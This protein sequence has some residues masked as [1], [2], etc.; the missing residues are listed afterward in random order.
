MNAALRP[1][2]FAFP[3]CVLAQD[4]T[5]STDVKVVTLLASVRNPD[6]N[7][8]KDLTKDDFELREDGR[9]QTIP[10]FSRAEP[11][12]AGT[13]ESA[14]GR[15]GGRGGGSGFGIDSTGTAGGWC[16]KRAMTNR[17]VLTGRAFRAPG[18]FFNSRRLEALPAGG[19]KWKRHTPAAGGDHYC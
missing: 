17:P 12:S 15:A 5:F 14:A 9:L 13:H 2:A 19:Y 11:M 16:L 10:Y 4:A 7:I 18:Q 6:G 3:L 1:L 8:V